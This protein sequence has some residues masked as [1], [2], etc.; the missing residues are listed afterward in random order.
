[1]V[2]KVIPV[3]KDLAAPSDP[4]DHPDLLVHAES[5][6][7]PDHGVLS[8]LKA[9]VEKWAMKVRRDLRVCRGLKGKKATSEP[10]DR[11]DSKVTKVIPGPPGRPVPWARKATRAR[12][13]PRDRRD[14][15]VIRA[16]SD[17]QDRKVT[18]VIPVLAENRVSK[19]HPAFKAIPVQPGHRD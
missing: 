13:E 8:V 18:K 4:S 3:R 5:R 19:A 6:V 9:R 11:K 14:S 17:L 12:L 10:Q 16:T 15:K 2:P 7:N 1:M